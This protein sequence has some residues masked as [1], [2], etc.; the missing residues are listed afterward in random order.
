MA[1]RSVTFYIDNINAL[2][3]IVKNNAAPAAIQA[4]TGLIWH[5]IR[6]LNITPLIGRVPSKRTI[7]DLPTSRVG[8]NQNP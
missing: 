7:A 1:N 8:I 2:L 4:M 6:V 5:R 3:E